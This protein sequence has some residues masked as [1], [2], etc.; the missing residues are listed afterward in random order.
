CRSECAWS[1]SGGT[2]GGERLFACA[3][4]GSEWVAGQAWTPVDWQGGIPDAVRAER[5]ERGRPAERAEHGRP[6]GRPGQAERAERAER[7]SGT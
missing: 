6:A 5:A 2:L 4:C 3:G 7:R 1:A